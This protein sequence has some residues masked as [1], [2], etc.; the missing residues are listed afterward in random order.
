MG[1]D[2]SFV[3]ELNHKTITRSD[4]DDSS[5]VALAGF[6]PGIF[7]SITKALEMRFRGQASPELLSQVPKD[8]EHVVAY[9]YL[10]K[11][12]AF[13][14]HFEKMRWGAYFSDSKVNGFGFF[15]HRPD[16]IAKAADQV[17]IHDYQS[18]NNF[19]IE[20][21][22]KNPK[23]RL[24][25]AKI[26]PES[27]LVQTIALVHARADTSKG[28]TPHDQTR[29]EIPMFNFRMIKDYKELKDK[30]ISS[31][32]RL[33]GW[34]IEYA[35]QLVRFKLDQEGAKLK[36]EAA[37]SAVTSAEVVQEEVPQLIFDRP[38]LILMERKG[39]LKGWTVTLTM[40][41]FLLT[42]LGTFM[43]RS[44]VFNSVHSFTQSAIG[45]T[46]LV[47]LALVLLWSVGLLGARIDRLSAEGRLEG[48]ASRDGMFL[49]N[50]LLFVLLTFTILIG[51]VFPLLV[52][53][54]KGVQM[55][56]GRP[57]FDRMA[58]PIGVA[59]LLLMGVGPALPW[60][61]ATPEQLRRA[62]VPPLAGAA[63]AA[64]LGALLG[65]RTPWTL[66]ALA[67][68][69]YTAQVTL[70]ELWL[71]VAR[72]RAQGAGLRQA[73]VESPL[74][75]GRRRERQQHVV[76]GSRCGGFLGSRRRCRRDAV[77][78][79]LMATVDRVDGVVHGALDD[80]Q[81]E[82]RDIRGP[83]GAGR[84][85]RRCVDERLDGNLVPGQHHVRCD[86]ACRRR[87][88]RHHDQHHGE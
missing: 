28:Q 64:G 85:R 10:F 40:A 3:S 80:R 53:A 60:G 12:L 13:E 55:S 8:P 87:Q 61:R 59:L 76:G 83:T 32:V 54:I 18:E 63:A 34:T 43:T 62:L 56:V 67:F 52:E 1:G 88:H 21:A 14:H 6:T 46:I 35:L 79:R 31:P 9:S 81:V 86:R 44:G 36:S 41:T 30:Q 22:T 84:R 25:L 71:P 11:D 66:V 27:T 5:Y 72:R 2:P 23:D 68:G 15:S 58:V 7:D 77:N 75:Q 69:G 51:T 82:D 57:Y 48:A 4:L 20:I 26:T 73:L 74:R 42:I 37:V 70:R 19:V 33:N 38:F 24:L 39:A 78:Q 17:R 29:L 16:S 65:V 50:N 49:A 45:P 47:F